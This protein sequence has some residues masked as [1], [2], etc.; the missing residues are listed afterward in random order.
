[1]DISDVFAR[2]REMLAMHRSQKEWLDVSQGLDSYLLTMEETSREVG[3]MS[4]RYEYAEGWTR[5]LPRGYCEE[6]ADPLSDIL[7]DRSF[8]SEEF[9]RD[10]G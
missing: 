6:D 3:R 4:D 10:L 2:K 7:R 8:V 9:E 1:V 5:H